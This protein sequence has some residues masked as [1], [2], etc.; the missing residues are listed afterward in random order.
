[1]KYIF[2]SLMFLLIAASCQKN[3]GRSPKPIKGDVVYVESNDYRD[4]QNKIIA[5]LNKGD[6]KLEELPASPFPAGGS[7]VGDPTQAL[8]PLDS[9]NQ[10]KISSDGHFLLAVNAGSNTIAVFYIQDDGSLTAVPGSPFPSGG[11][12]PVSIATKDNYVYVVNK[13]QDSVHKITTKPNYTVFSID[14][15]GTLTPVPQSTI[16]IS[17]GASPAQALVSN[18]GKFLFGADFLAFMLKPAQGTLRSFKIDADGKLDPVAG[19][20]QPIPMGGALGLAQN[21]RD[22]TLYVGSP[23][24][25]Q[26]DVYSIDGSSGTLN[27]VSSVASGPASCWLRTAHGGNNLYALNSAENSISVFNSS[28]TKSPLLT[29]K[30][31]L[32]ESGPLF[33]A[34]GKQNATSEDFSFEFSPTEKF[35]Y[36]VSQFANPDFSIGNFNYLHVLAVAA[37]GSLTETKDPT[38]LPVANKFRPQGV[39]VVHFSNL[40][41]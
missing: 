2:P 31:F 12:T 23:V 4:D 15:K 21:P 5:Y 36:V 13:A 25:G 7:G 29:N 14:Y 26:V 22:N 1:M 37:D 38:L 20:P 19:T 30:V 17:A 8:G 6:G 32:K 34:G 41:K 18:D 28:S 33:T 10:L 16:E 35:V 39:E 11:Q 24:T 27:F 3:N 40:S 9:D